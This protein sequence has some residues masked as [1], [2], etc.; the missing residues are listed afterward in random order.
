MNRLAFRLCACFREGGGDILD[1]L[2]TEREG[3]CVNLG[4]LTDSV[5]PSFTTST[6]V[7]SEFKYLP[8]AAVCWARAQVSAF[9]PKFVQISISPVD[10][11]QKRL[12]DFY[13]WS[14]TIY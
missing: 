2:Q 5:V 11:P 6:R 12:I 9:P 4:H 14:P 10:P 1:E 13:L 3:D 8:V 7:L